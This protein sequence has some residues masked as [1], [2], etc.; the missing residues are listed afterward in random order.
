LISFESPTFCG[1]FSFL[2]RQ[3]HIADFVSRCPKIDM[4]NLPLG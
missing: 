4:K 3:F 1:V 2:R